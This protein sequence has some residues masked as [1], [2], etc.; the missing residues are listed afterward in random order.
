MRFYKKPLS[1]RAASV[2]TITPLLFSMPLALANANTSVAV[3]QGVGPQVL[4]GATVFGNTPADTPVTVSIILKTV[5]TPELEQYIQQTVTPGNPQYRHYLSV[6]QFAAQFG[7]PAPVI[8]AITNYLHQFG[9]QTSVYSDNLNIT[10]NGTA[11]QFD[12]AFSV[13]L[14]NMK[15][16]GVNFHGTAAP[17]HMPVALADPILAVLGLTNYGNFSTHLVK[18]L[19]QEKFLPTSTDGP[20]AGSQTPADLAANYNVDPL[21]K[22]GDFGQGQTVGIVTLASVNP[23]DAYTFWKLNQIPVAPNRIQLVNVD[24]G[25]GPVS[26]MSGSVETTIDVE[27]AGALAPQANLIVYQAPNTDYGF[28]DAFF[29]AVTANQADAISTSWGESETAVNYTIAQGQ[30]SPNYA[31]V[32]NEIFMEGASQGISMF[33]AAGDAGAYDAASDLGTTNLSVDNPADSPYI[34]AAGGTTLPGIQN[35]GAF[36][37]DIPQQRTWG[38]N[39]LWPYWQQFGASSEA[40]FAEALVVGS[41]GGYSALFPT[42]WYQQHV[43]GVNQ[44]F[45]VPNLVPIDHNTAWNFNPDPQVIRGANQGRNVPDLALNA[46]PAT[47]YG[48]YSSTLFGNT[49]W[50]VYGGTSFVAPQLAGLTA[51]IN[52]QAEGRVGFWNGQ[53]YRFATRPQSPFQPLDTTGASND[54]LYYTGAQGAIYNPGSGLG[55]PNIAALATDF[56]QHQE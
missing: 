5:H 11:G 42:P 16:Q 49:E 25:A 18:P 33:A 12:Q 13:Q 10:A 22:E 31:Q 41:G 43:P 1:I 23:S 39:Y 6:S 29:N 8:Q 20:P 47:G 37:I 26:A 15:F 52:Q 54:N 9:I 38:W 27:Q 7:Q 30:E 2:L 17:P 36:T 34:T 48:V 21:Y 28:A 24:G 40:S 46:D 32:F 4:N 3:P 50:A 45:A 51:L 19:P 35:Y 14:Q 55:V 44:Y 53:I 56:S